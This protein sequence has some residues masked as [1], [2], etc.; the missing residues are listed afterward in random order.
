MKKQIT[1]ILEVENDWDEFMMS[2]DLKREIG[3]ASND[4]AIISI[5]TQII[6]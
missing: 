6:D 2:D 5:E 3:C 4:Y 1:V